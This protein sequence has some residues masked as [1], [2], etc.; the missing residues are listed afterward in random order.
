MRHTGGTW[1]E[2][3]SPTNYVNSILSA[4]CNGGSGSTISS[5]N[6]TQCAGGS[7]ENK[8]NLLVCGMPANV[9]G[10]EGWEK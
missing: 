5:V 1:Y 4:S 9:P 6:V 2:S 8:N 7:V 10:G 3:C